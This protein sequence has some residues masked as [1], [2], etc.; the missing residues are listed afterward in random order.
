MI[1]C[2]AYAMRTEH[3]GNLLW[4]PSLTLGLICAFLALP[5][6]AE[7]AQARFWTD[8]NGRV[9]K[10]VL[11]GVSEDGNRAVFSK[12]GRPEPIAI[13]IDGLSA[14]DQGRI[15]A[16]ALPKYEL[17]EGKWLK[18]PPLHE[19][20]KARAVQPM[21]YTKAWKPIPVE[22]TGVDPKIFRAIPDFIKS[23]NMGTTGLMI[24]VHGREAFQYGDIKEVSYIASCRKSVLSM[25]YGNYVA[26][27]VI[28]L[29]QTVGDL[30][31]QDVGGLL[32]IEKTATVL[33]LITARS[34]VYHAAAN[35]G[36]IPEGKDRLR[37]I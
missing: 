11:L 16:D 8:V 5:L 20:R 27:G 17:H 4:H 19:M 25:M 26:K 15:D 33:D 32:P 24:I 13:P 1:Y 3:C 2:S 30:E 12:A 28:D 6:A 22:D 10:A 23:R 7:N 21:T 31:I 35:T 37:S 34:G 14:V 29:T 36:G 9:V 18:A